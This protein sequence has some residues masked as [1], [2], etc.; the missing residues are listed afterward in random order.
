MSTLAPSL[1]PVQMPVVAPTP[2][3]RAERKCSS[4]RS[5]ALPVF[6]VSTAWRQKNATLAALSRNAPVVLDTS[7][8][9]CFG[10][11]LVAST[12]R[13]SV[14]GRRKVGLA[15]N[16]GEGTCLPPSASAQGWPGSRELRAMVVTPF[17]LSFR[18]SS[19]SS[20]RCGASALPGPL[21]AVSGLTIRSSGLPS[22]AAELKR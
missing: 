2:P 8:S 14:G 3:D 7:N 22:A 16:T 9:S 5:A 1:K 11:H 21:R 13:P 10:K 6:V 12:G 4:F 20:R 15:R 19:P 17:A 18:A